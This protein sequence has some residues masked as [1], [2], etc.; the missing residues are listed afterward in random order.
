MRDFFRPGRSTVHALNGMCATSHPLAAE[1]AIAVLREGGNAVDAAIAASAVLCVVE[2]MS[3]GIGGDCFVLLSKG[4]SGEVIGLNGSGRAP[5]AAS[6][7]ALKAR[8]VDEIGLSSVHSV[9]VPGAI[10]AWETLARDHGRFELARLLDPAIRFAEDGFPVSPRIGRDWRLLKRRLVKDED[11]ARHF[12]F[13]DEGPRT[14]QVVRLPALAETLKQVARDGRSG[15][16]EGRVAEDMVA[17]LR[18]LGGF[19]TVEDFAA[20]AASYVTPIRTTYKGHDLL[21]IPPNGQGITALIMLNVL[22]EFGIDGLDP[23]GPERM[24]LEAE[25]SRL[26]YELRDRYVADPAFADVPVEAL[27]SDEEAKRLAARIDPGRVM[28]D[29]AEMT[30][31]VYRDTVYLSVVDRDRNAV[32]FINSLYFGF[33]SAICSPETGVMFQNRG[34]SFA[35]DAA[36]T[37]RIEGG[38]RPM[39]T[40]IPAMLVEDGRAT[41]PFGVM[42]GAYQPVGQ[43]HFLTNLLDYGMDVQEALDHPRAF[44]EKGVLGVEP[45]VPPSVREALA[46]KGHEVADAMMPWGGGQAVQID[47][48]QGGLIGGSDPRKDGAAIGY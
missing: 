7:E 28:A 41:M 45:T 17:K 40:I 9:T 5:A 3:T 6:V 16:Y 43:V 39:H 26:A 21:E 18:A 34:A 32:S 38:K 31:P 11:A 13:D 12:L 37:N 33:G 30:G 24:H 10:D 42:G 35:V 25:A 48:K 20:T 29:I 8:G 27:L 4:G 15:F 36:H 22:R 1:T 19:H 44:H 14:G 47:W 46:A 23:D 2:P